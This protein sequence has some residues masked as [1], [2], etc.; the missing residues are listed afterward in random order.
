MKVCGP[1]SPEISFRSGLTLITVVLPLAWV[2]CM[3]RLGR[4]QNVAKHIWKD[5]S[6]YEAGDSA[7]IG[8]DRFAHDGSIV[9]DIASWKFM[10][11]YCPLFEEVLRISEIKERLDRY[12]GLP[13]EQFGRSIL[14]VEDLLVS[15]NEGI[16]ILLTARCT[17]WGSTSVDREGRSRFL[18]E[19]DRLIKHYKAVVAEKPSLDPFSTKGILAAQLEEI[20]WRVVQLLR[21]GCSNSWKN[22]TRI[23]GVSKQGAV[24]TRWDVCPIPRGS[25]DLSTLMRFQCTL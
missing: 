25:H 3:L 8:Q 21:R 16:E 5:E 18:R 15:A 2:G 23:V 6:G 11:K 1:Q 17:V 13:E 20:E 24:S 10:E 22:L 9:I 7:I 19:I 14:E 4:I 12:H